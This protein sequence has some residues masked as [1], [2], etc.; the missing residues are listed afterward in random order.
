MANMTTDMVREDLEKQGFSL[1][2]EEYEH[3][4]QRTIRKAKRCGKG[5]DYIPVL[6]ENEI[7]DYFFRHTVTFESALKMAIA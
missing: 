5:Q 3:I 6:L 2:D 1:M 4:L 7:R